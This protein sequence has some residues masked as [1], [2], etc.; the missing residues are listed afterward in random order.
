MIHDEG[1]YERAD[2]KYD[3]A[4]DK[5]LDKYSKGEVL[6]DREYSLIE[7]IIEGENDNG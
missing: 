7:N 3:V 1:Y 4:V 2:F 5:A 6:T